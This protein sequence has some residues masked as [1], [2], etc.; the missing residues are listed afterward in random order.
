MSLANR[1]N[2]YQWYAW[3]QRKGE[4]F[5]RLNFQRK[6]QENLPVLHSL[7]MYQRVYPFTSSA[8]ESSV[9]TI[10]FDFVS[11]FVCKFVC[12][13][14]FL[15]VY[16]FVTV[17]RL[18]SWLIVFFVVC[19]CV[20]LCLHVCLRFSFVC[21]FLFLMFSCVFDHLSAYSSFDQSFLG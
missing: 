5:N 17:I 20:R 1:F 21:F 18:V 8:G 11:M 19:F 16:L 13:F 2:L 4:Y 3:F 12:L 14:G 6:M 10:F 9:M 7:F 15:L